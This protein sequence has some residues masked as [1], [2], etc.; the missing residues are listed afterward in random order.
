[1]SQINYDG[2]AELGW[3][4]TKTLPNTNMGSHGDRRIDLNGY[5]DWE[6]LT[7]VQKQMLDLEW[8]QLS[9]KEKRMFHD[10]AIAICDAYVSAALL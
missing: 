10:A 1:M 9:N 6:R 4:G 5:H 3:R 8:E 2:L 7:D